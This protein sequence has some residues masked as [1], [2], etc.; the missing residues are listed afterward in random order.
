M[1][2]DFSARE[3]FSPP[4]PDA[5]AFAPTPVFARPAKTSRRFRG[6]APSVTTAMTAPAG[7]TV[8]T[9]EPLARDHVADEFER[10]AKPAA[11]GV[12]TAV[13]IAVPA[14]LAVLGGAYYWM[15][16]HDTGPTLAANTATAPPALI[17]TPALETP[18]APPAE[19]MPKVTPA[20]AAVAERASAPAAQ[21]ARATRV[22]RARPA[23][24][25]AADDSAA[26]ASAVVPASPPMETAPQSAAPPAAST[27]PPSLTIPPVAGAVN[28]A[29]L[30]PPPEVMGATPETSADPASATP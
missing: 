23:P 7:E 14:A 11:R 29:P 2:V 6:A 18:V 24:A 12:P 10:P 19:T 30:A 15:Q 1:P 8:F 16:T 20:P 17:T 27:A 4:S 21:P 5:A 22:A 25:P 13:L 26:D 9:R 3:D 28:P